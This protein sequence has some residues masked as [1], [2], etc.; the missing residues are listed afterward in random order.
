[1]RTLLWHLSATRGPSSGNSGG[2]ADVLLLD[3]KPVGSK[4]N[5]SYYLVSPR[6][7]RGVSMAE[8]GSFLDNL[9]NLRL[10]LSV[11][12]EHIQANRNEFVN[13]ATEN[14][15]RHFERC[16]SQIR[17]LAEQMEREFNAIEYLLA[18]RQPR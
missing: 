4:R 10:V 9:K 7:V 8:P 17:P 13:D 2:G 15:V 1:M 16:I 3:A 6:V 11:A 18:K 5:S 14:Q 12:L